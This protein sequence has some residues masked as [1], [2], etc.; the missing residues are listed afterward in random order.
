M[1]IF[2]FSVSVTLLCVPLAWLLCFLGVGVEGLS[3]EGGLEDAG[4]SILV[5][6]NSDW[7]PHLL[8]LIFFP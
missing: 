5:R 6:G 4:D 7:F 2:S 3:E 1:F 8:S